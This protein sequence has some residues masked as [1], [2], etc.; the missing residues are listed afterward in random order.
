MRKTDYGLIRIAIACTILIGPLLVLPIDIMGNSICIGAQLNPAE[1]D[2]CSR[3]GMAHPARSEETV[4]IV[5]RR[6]P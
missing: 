6:R 2:S 3:E 5:H 1:R 4:D